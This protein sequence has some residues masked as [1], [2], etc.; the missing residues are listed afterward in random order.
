MSKMFRIMNTT[1]GHVFGV[2]VADDADLAIGMMMDDAGAHDDEPG[3]DVVATPLDLR[4]VVLSREEAV[5]IG[6][7]L[8]G[9]GAIPAAAAA[10]AVEVS[11]GVPALGFTVDPDADILSGLT[12]SWLDLPRR[13]LIE[14]A[15]TVM[16]FKKIG[17]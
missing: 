8:D 1:S 2:Y 9:T 15:L 10:L 12:W 11:G 17:G 3:D 16:A 7:D 13:Q 5:E 4:R 6:F 14:D